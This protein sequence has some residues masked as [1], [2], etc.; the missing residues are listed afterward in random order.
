MTKQQPVVLRV[1]G[2]SPPN[3]LG[4]AIANEL[5]RGSLVEL[6]SIGAQAS[7]AAIKGLCVA[8]ML[9]SE[10]DRKSL[11]CQPNF[12]TL[13]TTREQETRPGICIRAWLL[14]KQE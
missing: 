9:L 12:V 7:Y 1:A 3:D 5:R 8:Q 11:A 13:R 10:N 2:G 6:Q 4:G 14:P